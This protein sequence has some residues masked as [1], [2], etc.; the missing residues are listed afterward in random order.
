M[1]TKSL[2]GMKFQQQ[3]LYFSGTHKLYIAAILALFETSHNT[4]TYVIF[5]FIVSTITKHVIRLK[6]QKAFWF[7]KVFHMY[8]LS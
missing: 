6:K 5:L 7:E 8:I 3:Y 4:L 2:C 1:Q